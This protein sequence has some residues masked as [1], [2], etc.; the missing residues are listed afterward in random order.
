MPIVSA[1]LRMS[2]HRPAQ[3]PAGGASTAPC[4]YLVVHRAAS[5]IELLAYIHQLPADLVATD[6]A[7]DLYRLR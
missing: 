2:D 5:S 7:R 1:L 4:R 3:T 6:D